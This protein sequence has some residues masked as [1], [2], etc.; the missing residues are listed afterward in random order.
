LQ[1]HVSH[2]RQVLGSRDAIVPHPPGYLLDP[3]CVDTDVA[4]AE[5]LI[6]DGAPVADRAHARQL[7]EALALWRGR[8]LSDVAGLSWRSGRGAG[9]R[10]L[11]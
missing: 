3:A 5:R 6:R 11:R 7:R 9:T 2:L 8:S 1:S 4:A 10:P